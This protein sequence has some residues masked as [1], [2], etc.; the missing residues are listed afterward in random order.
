MATGAGGIPQ[1]TAGV[2]AQEDLGPSRGGVFA[3]RQDAKK[4]K[5]AHERQL[6]EAEKK[7][8]A[9][10]EKAAKREQERVVFKPCG[11]RFRRPEIWRLERRR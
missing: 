4:Q 2:A 1:A 5:E 3:R 10:R 6:R 9:E 11:W 7:R 8:E